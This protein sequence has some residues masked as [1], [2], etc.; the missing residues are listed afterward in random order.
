MKK[1][2]IIILIFI[3]GI[4]LISCDNK[5]KTNKEQTI[6]ISKIEE[7]SKVELDKEEFFID[8]EI[9][10]SG[11]VYIKYT[12]GDEVRFSLK[13]EIITFDKSNL[14]VGENEVTITYT[15]ED[16]TLTKKITITIK[17]KEID[18]VV[19]I[20]K[21]KL[22]KQ[23]F[24]EGDEILLEGTCVL[25]TESG[26]YQVFNFTAT[27]VTLPDNVI[28]GENKA[29]V[30]Y[31]DEFITLSLEVTFKVVAQATGDEQ[32]AFEV[33]QF[34]VSYYTNYEITS[35]MEFIEEYKGVAID[36]E[37]KNT[38]I[39]THGGKF[40]QPILDTEIQI[41]YYFIVGDNEYNGLITLIAKGYGDY[42]DATF[43]ELDKIV[44]KKV[45]TDFTLITSYE[46][47]N[48]SIIWMN[49]GNVYQNGLIPVP[50]QGDDYYLTITCRVSAGGKSR[51][52]EYQIY[53]SMLT[54]IQKVNKVMDYY[55]QL[56][57]D[58]VIDDDY[59]LPSVDDKYG[60]RLT[61]LSYNPDMLT[62]DGKYT[63]PMF[64]ININFF[65]TVT[66]GNEA[67]R[68]I[69]TLRLK[70]K[71]Y[72]DTWE[73]IEYFL[74]RIHQ[75][76]IKTQKYTLYGSEPGYYYVTAYN[77]GYL[78]FY[79]TEELRVI[80]DFIPNGTNLKPDQNRAYTYF[81]TLHNTGMA[82]PTATAKGLND[83]IHST[84]RQASWHFAIDDKE[85]YNHVKLNEVTWHAG[86]GGRSVN[87]IY[88]NE[89]YKTYSIGGG[90]YYSVSIEMCVNEGGDFNWT[91]RNTAKLVSKLLVMYNLNTSRIRGHFHF[92]GKDCP[93]VILHA[94]RWAEMLELINLEYFARTQL[95]GVQFEWTS[96]NP[97]IMD[98]TG[99]VIN[100]PKV[101][102]EISYKVK[103]TYDGTSREYTYTSLLQKSKK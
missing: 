38:A 58:I 92:S 33:E 99:T 7:I 14:K 53:C 68:K 98:N 34:L 41:E 62:D 8:E 73:K 25:T 35:N 52:K 40:T 48:A 79:T 51:E 23:V 9:T 101:D 18:K 61:W 29:T 30:T 31:K 42:V 91:M 60:C 66:L 77:E 64:D 69:L 44:P 88:Y 54:D 37:S 10:L 19:S 26:A 46:E 45:Y 43:F 49:D 80:E 17:E 65:L 83:Y 103:V 27:D 32:L 90:N 4:F 56:F 21:P 24:T 75:D 50:E 70:G 3:F 55:Y 78:P 96:L 85:A 76:E 5:E 97:D 47:Y 59:P 74:D 28:V 84:T 71:E 15:D 20:S 2:R 12:D 39:L 81:I 95:Q 100:N 93:Q 11:K 6:D 22:K 57:N 63:M 89:S 87:Q 36:Y 94:G 67:E 13:D 86:D 102:T 72:S 1:I 82:A 16:I